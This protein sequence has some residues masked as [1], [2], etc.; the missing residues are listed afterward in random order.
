MRTP[1]QPHGPSDSTR[2]PKA[3]P[4]MATSVSRTKT[5]ACRHHRRAVRLSVVLSQR[6]AQ[7]PAS[8]SQQ[9][10]HLCPCR[11]THTCNVAGKPRRPQVVRKRWKGS[12]WDG[13]C[14]NKQHSPLSLTRK[15]THE[16]ARGVPRHTFR[17]QPSDLTH[18]RL[19]S[20]AVVNARDNKVLGV[21][22]FVHSKGR[23]SLE[24]VFAFGCS[25]EPE[26]VGAREKTFDGQEDCRNASTSAWL[27]A[28]SAARQV[29]M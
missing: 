10:Q 11:L 21:W 5:R 15:T 26:A 29:V 6:A 20:G 19:L 16:T 25:A 9:S 23:R 4:S 13:C 22:D 14:T 1:T 3:A 27:A 18:E 7:S 24:F 28:C 2:V 12:R 17:T 8:C